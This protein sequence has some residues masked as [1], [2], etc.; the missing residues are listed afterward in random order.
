MMWLGI[1]VGVVIFGWVVMELAFHS[2]DNK[3]I[4]F[5]DQMTAV[6]KAVDEAARYRRMR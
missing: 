6:R 2:M 5:S 3:Y 1:I 4:P